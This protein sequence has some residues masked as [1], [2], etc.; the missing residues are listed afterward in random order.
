MSE[1]DQSL[2][3]RVESLTDKTSGRVMIA[4]RKVVTLRKEEDENRAGV[5]ANGAN[6]GTPMEV[7]A[8]TKLG[9][10]TI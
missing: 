6:N 10:L 9:V 3:C 8:D 2:S 5:N 7:D 1:S 4:R